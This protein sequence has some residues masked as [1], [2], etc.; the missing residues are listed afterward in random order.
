M[1]VVAFFVGGQSQ[2]KLYAGLPGL[3]AVIVD[4]ELALKLRLPLGRNYG[5]NWGS[6]ARYTSPI[7][8]LKEDDPP[9]KLGS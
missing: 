4:R 2:T 3:P 1:A 8:I 9:R 5:T 6:S 7:P